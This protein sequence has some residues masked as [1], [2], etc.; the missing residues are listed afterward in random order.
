MAYFE[1][2]INVPSTSASTQG[3]ITDFEPTEG[4]LWHFLVLRFMKSQRIPILPIYKRTINP[5]NKC[6]Q[7]NVDG[8]ADIDFL[9]YILQK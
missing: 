6:S 2:V 3:E 1:Q 4:A 5:T 7:S 8:W 9:E